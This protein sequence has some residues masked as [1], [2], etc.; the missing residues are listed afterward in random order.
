MK[1]TL[2][3]FQA[4]AFLGEVTQNFVGVHIHHGGTNRYRQ[5]QVFA[6]GAGAVAAGA[7]L[8]VLGLV[9]ALEAVIDQRV[10][11]AVCFQIDGT[12]IPAVTAVRAAF[13]HVFFPPETQ[14]AMAALAGFNNDGGFVYKF[15][16]PIAFA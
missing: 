11:G 10:Q 1:T 4:L 2:C 14:A 6:L 15:H 16:T 8:A 9:F 5:H 12:A 3:H 7:G 13:R